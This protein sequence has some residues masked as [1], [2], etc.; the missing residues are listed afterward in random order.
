MTEIRSKIEKLLR[1]ASDRGATEDEAATAMRLA[2][3]LMARHG[4]E[5]KLEDEKPTVAVTRH[6]KTALRD[7][8]LQLAG[9]SADLYG[10]TI[11]VWDKGRLGVEFVGRS[12]NID[13]AEQTMIFLQQQVEALYKEALPRGL[14]QAERAE[15]RRTFKFACAM[16]VR[17]RARQ[18]VADLQTS[19]AAAQAA[20]G[21]T[22]LVVL[23]HFETLRRENEVALA[24]FSLKP[25]RAVVRAMG[26]GTAAGRAAGDRVQLARRVSA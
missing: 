2:A 11:V 4:I 25:R 14:T 5:V 9:A 19:E 18:I 26:S 24:N 1:L 23:S 21:S 10:C 15:F 8:E 20:T 6:A 13:A 17:Q 3:G 7:Y 16:R 12:D 22:A